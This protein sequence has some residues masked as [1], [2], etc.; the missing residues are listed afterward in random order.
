MP[1]D[2]KTI[3][4]SAKVGR[5]THQDALDALTRTG[6]GTMSRFIQACLANLIAAH[7]SGERIAEPVELVRRLKK[8]EER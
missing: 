3:T 2:K 4:V 7:Q 5:R 1:V 8:R 6:A